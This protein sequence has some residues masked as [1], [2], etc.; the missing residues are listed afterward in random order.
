MTTFN[1][2]VRTLD[3]ALVRPQGVLGH[4][5]AMLQWQWPSWRPFAHAA[6]LY[7][8]QEPFVVPATGVA[9]PKGAYTVDAQAGAVALNSVAAQLHAGRSMM[10]RKV[11]EMVRA[12]HLQHIQRHAGDWLLPQ[13]GVVTYPYFQ[14]LRFLIRC[15]LKWRPPG[16]NELPAYGQKRV[17]S[18]LTSAALRVVFH[19]YD[20]V[21][22]HCDRWTTPSDLA[23]TT[24]LETV[25][26]ELTLRT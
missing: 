4:A 5:I 16:V 13:V 21:P 9:M 14:L 23:A 7:V 15:P 1:K 18:A 12:V 11:P 8:A 10:I 24:G 20:A 6:P 2:P 25:T 26:R 19:G 3:I 22:E 17:C